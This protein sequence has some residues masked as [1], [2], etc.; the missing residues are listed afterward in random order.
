MIYSIRTLFK[1][2]NI[3]DL[4]QSDPLSRPQNQ[5]IKKYIHVHKLTTVFERQMNN[6]FSGRWLFHT[7]LSLSLFV[8]YC[9]FLLI[10]SIT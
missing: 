4:I 1:A 5:K 2:C 7:S 9:L 8:R 6:S 3:R 10:L